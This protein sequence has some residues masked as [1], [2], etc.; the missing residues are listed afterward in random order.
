M[1]LPLK[2][3]KDY[4]N[5][6]EDSR[7]VADYLTTS[8]SHVESIISIKEDIKDIVV[9]KI[10]SLE[11]H[12]N[13]DK[14]L[15]C[16]IDI[17]DKVLDIVTGATNLKVGDYVPVALVGAKLPK[18]ITIERTEF[19][20][21]DSF[22]MLCSLKELGYSDNVIPKAMKDGIYVLDKEYKL[23]DSII[24]IMDLNEDIIEF[25]ITPNRP[26]C[27]SIL[28]MA[29]ETA[30]TFGIKVEEP[31]IAIKNEVEDI[32]D[33]VNSLN[34]TSLNC[35]RYY[36]KVIKDIKIEESPVW[37][38]TRLMNAGVRPINNIVDIT[39]FVM[40][41]YGEPLHAFDLEKIEGKSIIV[42]QAKKDEKIITLD[43]VERQLDESDLVIADAIRPIAI[44]GIMG[45]METEISKNTKFVFLEGA[46]FDGKSIRFTSKKF[47]LRSEAST[48][49]EK[50]IDPNLSKT[51]VDRACQLI[52]SI[53]AGTVISGEVDIYE[54]VIGEKTISLRPE[55]ANKMLGTGISTEDMIKY[56]NNL[57]ICS[58][59][60]ED[61][62][63][64]KIPTT[65]ADI[66]MEIDLIEEIG[67]LYGF[68]NIVSKPLV[69]VL[70]RGEK[71]YPKII[72]EKSKEILKGFGLNE[73]MT[74][75]FISPK[76]YDKINIS[77]DSKLRNYI[78]LINPLGEDYSIMRT[79]LIPNMLD[80][81]SKNYNKGVKDV[82]I[83]EI[84]SIF[85]PKQLPVVE[86]PN[87][88]KV[89]SFGLYGGKDF[90]FLKEVINKMLSSLGIKDVE[91][92]REEN[93]PSFHP[94]RTA[95]LLLSGEELGIIGE[96][97]MDVLE[98]Y[99]I[100]ERV[101]IG[102]LDFDKIVE[103]TNLDKKFK[104]LPKYPAITRDMAL[105]VEKDILVGDIENVIL[106]HGEGL[107]ENINLFDVYTGD[108]I[109][110]EMKSVAYSITYRAK[111]RTLRDEEVNSI[112]DSIIEDLKRVYNVK[113]RS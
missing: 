45:G 78:T 83:Y 30:A 26:D 9:G 8:G 61:M 66:E 42:R 43:E 84:G 113:L 79:T 5:I 72:E 18:N 105:I 1:L 36:G 2:W 98:N 100:K 99:N 51:A 104:A 91:Y 11:K 88:N 56:L 73:V 103:N 96:I 76:A 69:G 23:G 7:Q 32:N 54:N 63:Y 101:Y 108:Q 35:N 106:Q 52:E 21:I 28:G 34:V 39:N 65:R 62:I 48:R 27:L 70:T 55:R 60:R 31:K 109:S 71:P 17:G 111:D 44:A 86:L 13:A 47:G 95:K 110:N 67:R 77:E 14:L 38:Q 50:G 4:V 53:G 74:Y 40:L 93:D 64:S 3:L 6:K 20:G 10:S 33:Y 87:E 46:N 22:G 59:V 75:S 68:H 49:F 57:G 41:E 97:H 58:E 94:G 102:Q 12:D 85:L 81:L 19:R 112:Y 92:I 107:I 16:K 15:I 90:Y 37:I 89:L 24:Q 80:L 29:R 82:Y 25:E